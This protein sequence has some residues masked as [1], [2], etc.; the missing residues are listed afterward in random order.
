M[1]MTIT[2]TDVGT[3]AELVLA[4]RRREAGAYAELFRRWYQRSFNVA[5]AILRDREGAADVAQE[6]LLIGWQKLADL[7]DPEAFGPW[8]LRTTRNRAL[9]R[10]SQDSQRRLEP[11]EEHHEG[12][13]LDP[14]SDPALQ[15]ERTELNRLIWTA[16]NILG[17]RDTSLL[18]LH[19]RHGLQPMQIAEELRITS[20]NAKQLLFRLRLRLREAISALLLW[21]GGHPVCATLASLLA[22]AGSFDTHVA[23]TIRRHQR[24]CL[25]CLSE[26]S[27]QTNPERLFASVPFVVAPALF[28]ERAAHALAHAGVPMTPPAATAAPVVAASHGMGRITAIG[29]AVVTGLAMVSAIALWPTGPG[30]SPGPTSTPHVSAAPYTAAGPQLTTPPPSPTRPPGKVPLQSTSAAVAPTPAAP[31]VDAGTPGTSDTFCTYSFTVNPAGRGYFTGIFIVTNVSPAAWDDWRGTFSAT[32]AINVINSWGG[33]FT[34]AGSSVDITAERYTAHVPSRAS[35]SVGLA[36]TTSEATP[37]VS[38][39][40]VQGHICREAP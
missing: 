17:E 23:S 33:T 3:D 6:S 16:A 4:A 32:P 20:N 18:D 5:L 14:D 25:Q 1:T 19:L 24:D 22:E 10:L 2:E 37:H 21:R 9:N 30:T 8:I 35:V 34:T 13:L 26:V 40:A 12:S 15:A 11:I 29:G 39:F 27:T 28:Q 7:R 31:V 36:G 38:G